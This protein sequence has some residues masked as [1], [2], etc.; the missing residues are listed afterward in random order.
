MVLIQLKI[1]NNF[2]I[3]WE[4]LELSFITQLS[5]CMDQ[6][7]TNHKKFQW[8]TKNQIFKLLEICFGNDSEERTVVQ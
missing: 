6:L 4:V 1:A 3:E 5:V 2:I 8:K 7:V